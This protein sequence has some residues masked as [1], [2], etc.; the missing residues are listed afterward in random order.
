MGLQGLGG[1]AAKLYNPNN[2]CF[3]IGL[4]DELMIRVS[5]C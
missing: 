5:V 1:H 3:W 2:S 4:C